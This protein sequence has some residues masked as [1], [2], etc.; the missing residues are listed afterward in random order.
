MLTLRL[1]GGVDLSLE[2]LSQSKSAPALVAAAVAAEAPAAASPAPAWEEAFQSE[3]DLLDA[4]L[5][6]NAKLRRSLQAERR[7]DALSTLREERSQERKRI[8]PLRGMI[9]ELYQAES[10]LVAPRRE[11]ELQT[12]SKIRD[13]NFELGRRE[14]LLQDGETLQQR[15][16]HLTE[17]VRAMDV[18]AEPALAD[19]LTYELIQA[20]TVD[21]LEGD[22][23]RVEQKQE[24][25]DDCV[26]R[27]AQWSRVRAEGEDAQRKA[28]EALQRQKRA[29][30][31]QLQKQ[32]RLI[33][34]RRAVVKKNEARSKAHAQE[35]KQE[36][37]ARLDKMGELD[38]V[39]E[40][41][42]KQRLGTMKTTA[43]TVDASPPRWLHLS[44]AHHI[45]RL[46]QGSSTPFS[47]KRGPRS[48]VVTRRKGSRTLFTT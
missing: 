3:E 24:Q 1:Q 18:E 45:L 43:L 37:N 5:A 46:K 39:E 32:G 13:V 28:Y 12:H 6:E 42:L 41:R 31:K 15:L 47:R 20:R 33:G 29:C 30:E 10:A 8:P 35:I 21:N 17:Q 11:K 9:S 40:L 36:K 19:N 48:R 14:R 25:V 22:R 2:L 38:A 26:E 44:P 4:L 34:E 7:K 16:Q 27:I 23:I